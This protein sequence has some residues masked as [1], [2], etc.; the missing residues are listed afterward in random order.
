MVAV[1]MHV[2]GE[3]SFPGNEYYVLGFHINPKLLL[4]ETRLIHSRKRHT[5]A[6]ITY[7]SSRN[8]LEKHKHFLSSR[9]IYAHCGL[10]SRFALVASNEFF[11]FDFF[12]FSKRKIVVVVIGETHLEFVVVTGS[13][14]YSSRVEVLPLR[15][16]EE[17]WTKRE[18]FR[19]DERHRGRGHQGKTENDLLERL[20]IASVR[21]RA[22]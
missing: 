8:S 18:K 6:C 13:E 16:V 19:R 20:P 7:A 15:G 22:T 1:V 3:N 21:V 17:R 14:E 5:L 12:F 4:R 9:D 10:F 11:F 2:S